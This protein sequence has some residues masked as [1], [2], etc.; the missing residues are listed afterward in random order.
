MISKIGVSP[1]FTSRVKIAGLAYDKG[2][3]D[4]LND[5]LLNS[6]KMLEN[7]G[8]NDDVT[9]VSRRGFAL[10]G[11]GHIDML[12]TE[13]DGNIYKGAVAYA[14][15]DKI[16]STYRECKEALA[17][18]DD[19]RVEYLFELDTNHIYYSDF[20]WRRDNKSKVHII[21]NSAYGICTSKNELYS[22]ELKK[23]ADEIENNGKDEILTIGPYGDFNYMITLTRKNKDGKTISAYSWDPIG[24]TNS[25]SRLSKTYKQLSDDIEYGMLEF[26]NTVPEKFVDY[27]I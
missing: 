24:Y 23:F 16:L 4:Q 2:M 7:N 8:N 11:P 1:A 25:Y 6:I 19:S 14:P 3:K 10:F 13:K 20:G 15:S 27:V 17:T 22:P 9:L 5:D 21:P 18:G 26:A 12:V